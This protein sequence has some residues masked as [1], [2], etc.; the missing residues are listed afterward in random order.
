MGE[1]EG[2]TMKLEWMECSVQQTTFLKAAHMT[3]RQPERRERERQ[4]ERERERERERDQQTD[5]SP[6]LF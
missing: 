6:H 4:T 1:G 3:G 5:L 2:G